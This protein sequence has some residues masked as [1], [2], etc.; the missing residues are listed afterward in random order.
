MEG[1]NNRLYLNIG[2]NNDRGAA[3]ASPYGSR[4][5]SPAQRP[6][7]AGAPG[8]APSG[9]GHYATPPMPTQSAAPVEAFAPA[10]ERLYEKYGPNANNNQK[11]CTQLASDFFKDSVKRARERNQR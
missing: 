4:G 9:Y 11:K 7:T 3:R 1:N 5:P 8:Q 6:R 2:N 10:P